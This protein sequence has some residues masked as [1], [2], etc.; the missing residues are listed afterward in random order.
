MQSSRIFIS[1]H[2]I[3]MRGFLDSDTKPD[4][5]IGPIKL[6]PGRPTPIKHRIIAV[7]RNLRCKYGQNKL[8]YFFDF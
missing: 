2:H 3:R 4:E 8:N 1:N 7:S 6:K 5:T